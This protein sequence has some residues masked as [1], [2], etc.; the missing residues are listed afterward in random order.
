MFDRRISE[1]SRAPLIKYALL[2]Y[3]AEKAWD[4]RSSEEQ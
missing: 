2:I 4:Q 1:R 3:A